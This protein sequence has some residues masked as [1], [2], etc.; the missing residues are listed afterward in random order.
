MRH[1]NTRDTLVN[2]DGELC[3]LHESTLDSEP[4][5]QRLWWPTGQRTADV[6]GGYGRQIL[7]QTLEARGLSEH[8]YRFIDPTMPQVTITL[9][10]RGRTE[11]IKVERIPAP[12][13]AKKLTRGKP[14]RWAYGEWVRKLADGDQLLGVDFPEVR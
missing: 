13:P 5:I 2:L 9:K 8:G 12:A 3:V 7:C 1:P 4:T 6:T 10:D 11:A 14:V